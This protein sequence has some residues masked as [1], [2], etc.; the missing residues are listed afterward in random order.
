MPFTTL[1]DA[2]LLDDTS[3]LP[4]GRAPR[5]ADP[6]IEASVAI[7]TLATFVDLSQGGVG[8]ET[9]IALQLGQRYSVLV[10]DKD[11]S[12]TGRTVWMKLGDIRENAN[13]EFEAIYRAGIEFETEKA[14]EMRGKLEGWLKLNAVAPADAPG[15]TGD[16]DPGVERRRQERFRLD[17]A[18]PRLVSAR[19]HLDIALLS[20][21]GLIAEMDQ[22]IEPG[23]LA[24]VKLELPDGPLHVPAQAVAVRR[25]DADTP[26]KV[27]FEFTSIG[28]ECEA[29]LE[30]FIR[31]R[32]GSGRLDA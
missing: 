12:L 3:E 25:P 28:E 2:K 18:V 20:L 31:S 8:I 10:E 22:A 14:E 9:N 21:S 16:T 7:M 17:D 27:A 24:S 6:G 11:L 4:L 23:V 15:A 1:F 29:R 30:D 19:F 32:L 13:G 26:P 5:T